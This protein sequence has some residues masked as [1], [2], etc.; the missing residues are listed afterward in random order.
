M[1]EGGDGIVNVKGED[2]ILNA[3]AIRCKV[4]Q[5]CTRRFQD[6]IWKEKARRLREKICMRAM[7]IT[8]ILYIGHLLNAN[9]VINNL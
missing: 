3:I 7:L 8:H 1:R 4:E 2:G 5:P 6:K 9:I